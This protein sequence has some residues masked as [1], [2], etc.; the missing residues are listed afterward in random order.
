MNI[1]KL[2]TIEQYMNNKPDSL[3]FTILVD[4][5]MKDG[6]LEKAEEVCRQGLTHYSYLSEGYYLLAVILLKKGN[7]LEGIKHLQNTI[8]YCP[9]HIYA[10]KLLLQLGKENLSLREIDDSH[11]VIENFEK[12]IGPVADDSLPHYYQDFDEKNWTLKRS[13]KEPFLDDTDIYN[14]SEE[15]SNLVTN[16]DEL[17]FDKDDE[18]VTNKLNEDEDEKY[19][20]SQ[21][22]ITKTQQTESEK[23]SNQPDIDELDIIEDPEQQEDL[24]DQAEKSEDQTSQESIDQKLQ[25]SEFELDLDENIDDEIDNIPDNALNESAPFELDLDEEK[26]YLEQDDMNNDSPDFDEI[27]RAIDELDLDEDIDLE[28]VETDE[29]TKPSLSIHPVQENFEQKILREIEENQ[30][31]ENISEEEEQEEESEQIPEFKGTLKN[32]IDATSQKETKEKVNLNIPIPTLTF[33]EV[34]KNQKLYDQALEILELLEKR[35][36]EKEKIIQQKEEII[37]LK[38]QDTY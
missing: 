35:S 22:K 17:D 27:D 21:D 4:A 8:N 37:R 32:N 23:P 3:L 6:Q 36:S 26:D 12:K 11:K 29:K 38:A 18:P 31:E 34:L 16:Y 28:T 20:R 24:D 7:L 15:V 33:V 13:D 9:G 25:D 14:Q 30:S 10:H 2:E 5:L 19:N 1:L